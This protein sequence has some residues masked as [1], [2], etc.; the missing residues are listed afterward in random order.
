[1]QKILP[2]ASIT[3]TVKNILPDAPALPSLFDVLSD[4]DEELYDAE[5]PKGS[6]SSADQK[7]VGVSKED[8]INLITSIEVSRP[9]WNHKMSGRKIRKYKK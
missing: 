7:I 8:M 4:R 6:T 5:S 2:A 1:M 9:L 3:S